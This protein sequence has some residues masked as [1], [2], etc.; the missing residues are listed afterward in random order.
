VAASRPFPLDLA[1]PYGRLRATVPLPDRPVRLSE[2]V[3]LLLQ[4]DDQVAAQAVRRAGDEGRPATCGPACGACCRQLVPLS[5][6]EAFA[7]TSAVATLP[8][9]HGARVTARFAATAEAL[10]QH[11][12]LLSR[13]TVPTPDDAAAV[14]LAHDYFVLQ[15]PCPFLEDESCSV[16]PHRPSICR[17]HNVSSPPARCRDP[18]ANAVEPIASPVRLSEILARLHAHLYQQPGPLLIPLSLA[19]TWVADHPDL[20]RLAWPAEGLLTDLIAALRRAMGL[21][22]EP[23]DPGL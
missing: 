3:P 4:I 1:T 19:P 12:E 20:D 6:P 17:E 10:A 21:S 22:S 16:H 7:V 9:D 15:L 5:A 8:P 11:P 14:A 18:F 23:R 13:L 2:L